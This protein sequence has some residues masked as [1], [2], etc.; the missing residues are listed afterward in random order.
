MGNALF[1]L[2]NPKHT[3]LLDKLQELIAKTFWKEKVFI[4]GGFVRDGLL[5]RDIKDINVVVQGNSCAS[6]FA[7]WFAIR[8]GNFVEAKNPSYV[9]NGTYKYTFSDSE[10]DG[11][12]LIITDTHRTRFSPSSS[13]AIRQGCS[14]E[15][16]AKDR[17]LTI[18]SLYYDVTT[19]GIKTMSGS[20]I[21]DL[22]KRILRSPSSNI[23]E[24]FKNDPVRMLRIIRFS[25]E[26]KWGID[27][28]TWVAIVKNAS[29]IENAS[30]KR[31]REE[32]N[33]IL[34]TEQPSFGI[35]KLF[36]S[37]LAQYF[38]QDINDLNEVEECAYPRV[39]V[40]EQTM[41]ILDYTQPILEHRLAALFH[42]VGKIIS[43]S[44]NFFCHN[45]IGAECADAD[46]KILGYESDIRKE[47][48]KAIECYLLFDN[49]RNND[50]PSTHK[51]RSFV[52]LCGEMNVPTT[53]DLMHAYN[54]N[55]VYNRKPQLVPSIIKKIEEI[56]NVDK[57]EKEK[58]SKSLPV[59]GY[60]IMKT[61]GLKPSSLVGTLM[62]HVRRFCKT[63]PDATRDECLEMLRQYVPATAEARHSQ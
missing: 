45:I 26:L 42:G 39:T 24:S 56:N 38:I 50:I 9:G 43:E 61:F 54:C 20:G 17:D 29:L 25:S 30:Y 15:E 28:D 59:D 21:F 10:L 31:I 3:V 52:E 19:G 51:V 55:K 49:F 36:Y 2:K 5:G 4:V 32:L 14:I 12:E 16:D 6:G 13:V 48:R 34:L 35:Q 22:H 37:G 46:L 18:N 60:D 62:S 7:E 8:N 53:L 11:I 33:K 27:K 63:K 58:E 47:V 23:E 57:K 44:Q 40:F 41:D 1:K